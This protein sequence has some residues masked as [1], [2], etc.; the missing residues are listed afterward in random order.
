MSYLKQEGGND[1]DGKLMDILIRKTIFPCRLDKS[2]GE[3][4][5]KFFHLDEG[6]LASRKERGHL[7]DLEFKY[8]YEEEGIKYILLEEYLFKE[9]TLVLDINAAIG[10][11]YYLNKKEA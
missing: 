10:V 3:T 8:I 5:K 4:L 6:F 1:L 9:N 11:N 7:D 2:E